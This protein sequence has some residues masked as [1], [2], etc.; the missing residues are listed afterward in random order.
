[1]CE[2]KYSSTTPHVECVRIMFLYPKKK[3][4]SVPTSLHC[5]HLVVANVGASV[6]L[7]SAT[8]ENRY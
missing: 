2:F 3:R 1:M 6:D 4:V 5:D 7:D 8:R